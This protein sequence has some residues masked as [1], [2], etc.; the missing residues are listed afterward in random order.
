MISA[1]YTMPCDGLKVIV[2]HGNSM[3]S[4]G[5]MLDMTPHPV[6]QSTVHSTVRLDGER[7]TQRP[8][9]ALLHAKGAGA[10]PRGAHRRNQRRQH[11]QLHTLPIGQRHHLHL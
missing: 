1:L 3:R 2:H 5:G 4:L 7:C 10:R 11:V 6:A 9:T 8:L